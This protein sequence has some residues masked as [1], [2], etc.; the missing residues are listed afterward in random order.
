[1]VRRSLARTITA[2]ELALCL[3][4]SST[5][6]GSIILLLRVLSG[7]VERT[8]A[9]V[10][11]ALTLLSASV[12]AVIRARRMIPP[13][14]KLAAV[15]DSMSGAGG[16]L[17]AST[18]ADVGEW[19][20]RIQ[21]GPLPSV[22]WRARRSIAAAISSLAFLLLSSFVPNHR[23][24][25]TSHLDV[26]SQLKQ[27][28][29][30]LA[31]LEAEKVVT[32]DLARDEA[33]SLAEIARNKDADD[34]AR[35]WDALD[36]IELQH[37]QAADATSDEWLRQLE[38]V[39][40]AEAL[41]GG[42]KEARGELDAGQTAEATE[43]IREA[44]R[45]AGIDEAT[46]KATLSSNGTATAEQLDA[47]MK[48]L[49]AHRG[50]LENSMRN[51]AASKLI[52]PSKVGK[53]RGAHPSR[54]LAQYL[55]EELDRRLATASPGDQGGMPG[56]GGINRGRGD[57]Q[58]VFGKESDAQGAKFTDQVLQSSANDPEQSEL[59]GVTVGRPGSENASSGNGGASTLQTGNAHGS[60]ITQPILPRHRGTV[61]RYFER[62]NQ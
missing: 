50:A 4:I 39:S 12:A 11:I 21:L 38:A 55:K 60:A 41:E 29:E 8:T 48:Q 54:E 28:K 5:I 19:R 26:T 2:R 36:Q 17:V 24:K 34:P 20:D 37:R 56:R 40:K 22:R 47:A 49:A 13:H 16:L 33:K 58:L 18:E 46:I 15:I 51:L 62:K 3:T 43:A 35:S 30:E 27:M 59:I 52:D 1:M 10:L 61:T 53:G 14:P 9:M 7:R 42:L 32:P 23:F 44:M 25:E 31:V 45:E 57:A 6:G